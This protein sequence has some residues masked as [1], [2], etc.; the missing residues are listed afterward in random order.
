MIPKSE[1]Q[2][3]L[4]VG[5]EWWRHRTAEAGAGDVGIEIQ[6][7]SAMLVPCNCTWRCEQ[8]WING[9]VTQEQQRWCVSVAKQRPK[10]V[11]VRKY[12]LQ[13]A[14]S[15]WLPSF[16]TRA[17]SAPIAGGRGKPHVETLQVRN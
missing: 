16:L 9:K 17:C 15:V 4:P 7:L 14:C 2:T 13:S 3:D 10:A 1:G 5:P 11:L 6:P 12:G 8:L